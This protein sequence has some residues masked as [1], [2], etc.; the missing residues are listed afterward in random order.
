MEVVEVTSSAIVCWIVSP[1]CVP[2]YGQK[3]GCLSNAKD[4]WHRSQ[5]KF[6][7]ELTFLLFLIH[8]R[9]TKLLATLPEHS[10]YGP[11]LDQNRHR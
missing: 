8:A 10:N 11:H 9:V 6:T 4:L 5:R 3:V 1:I 2:Q 7:I